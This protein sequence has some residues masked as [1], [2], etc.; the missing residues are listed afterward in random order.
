MHVS[1]D[2][3]PLLAGGGFLRAGF[4]VEGLEDWHATHFVS[5]ALFDTKQVSQVHEPGNGANLLKRL[6]LGSTGFSGCFTY[7]QKY[8]YNSIEN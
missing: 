1:Q 8:K 6:L 2:Q 3:E 7:H 5:V 4:S